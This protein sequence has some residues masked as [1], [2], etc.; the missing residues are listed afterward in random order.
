MFSSPTKGGKLLKMFSALII[1]AQIYFPLQ[2]CC[3]EFRFPNQVEQTDTQRAAEPPPRFQGGCLCCGYHRVRHPLLLGVRSACFCSRVTANCRNLFARHDVS[4]GAWLS[5]VASTNYL[6]VGLTRATI[7]TCSLANAG[8]CCQGL[9]SDEHCER[10][11]SEHCHGRC[12]GR[13]HCDGAGQLRQLEA[14]RE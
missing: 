10:A 7:R 6:A 9:S 11:W 3:R 14:D 13:L 2:C 12:G 5:N 4:G 1:R 8:G